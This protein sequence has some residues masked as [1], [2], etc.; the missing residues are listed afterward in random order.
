MN[1]EFHPLTRHFPCPK[2][3]VDRAELESKCQK[4]SWDPAPLPSD[5]RRGSFVNKG[6]S[7]TCAEMNE[8]FELL[9]YYAAPTSVF[10]SYCGLFQ[11]ARGD[12]TGIVIGVLLFAIGGSSFLLMIR[13][14]L[15]GLF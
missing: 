15:R 2:C 14:S 4:C 10:V 5:S 11:I 12:T 6:N 1:R 3:G 8:A 13:N 7:T 9:Y